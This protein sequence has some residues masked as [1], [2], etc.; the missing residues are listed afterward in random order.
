[1]LAGFEA[2]N[3]DKRVVGLNMVQPEDGPI[4]MRDY[5]LHMQMVGFLHQLYPNVRISLHA[6]E[7]NSALVPADGLMFHIQDA[8]NVANASRIGHGV[9]I[10]QEENVGLLLKQMADRRILVEINL[11]SNAAILNVEGK[12]HPLPLYMRYGV[13]VTLSTDD[14]GVSRSNLTKEYQRAVTTFQLSYLTIKK[15]IRNSIAYAFLPGKSLWQDDAYQQ[16]VSVCDKDIPGASTVLSQ[17][18]EIFLNSN[19]KASAQWELEK[20]FAKFENKFLSLQLP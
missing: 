2:A 10:A 14:E 13:P 8:V 20:R 11:S 18:C 15:F 5:K 9:D 19:E 1:L 16:R 17:H 7:L 6:G 3:K 4:S 12:D